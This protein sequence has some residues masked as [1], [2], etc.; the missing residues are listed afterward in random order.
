MSRALARCSVLIVSLTGC[1]PKVA[2]IPGPLDHL[3]RPAVAIGAASPTAPSPSG[4]SEPATRPGRTT[5]FQSRVVDAAE[6]YLDAAPKGFRNDCS[7]FVMAVF[8]RAGLPIEGSTASI[9]EWAREHGYLNHHKVPH[10]G[11]LAFFDDTWDRNDN[12]RLDDELSH[13]AVVISVD[14][15][16]TITL[17]HA[18]TS[19][20]R[21]TLH[22]NLEEASVHEDPSGKVVND[23]L[24]AKNDDDPRKTE[25]LAGEL[26]R[27]FATLPPNAITPE[28]TASVTP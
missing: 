15:D 2:R 13:I 23:W 4:S 16:G 6:H 26:W 28:S 22:M 25:Y 21:T 5:D 11:D 12:G 7:G 17:A 18:G 20:G 8:A 1:A 19:H 3:G 10:P 9:Y 14:P 24:R 27:A